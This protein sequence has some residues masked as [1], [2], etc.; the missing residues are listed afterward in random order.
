[1]NNIHNILLV[2][3]IVLSVLLTIAILLQPQGAS[4]GVMWGATSQSYH[5]RRGFEKILH[6]F[7]YVGVVLFVVVGLVILKTA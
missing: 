6:Y 4:S 5:T 1:M 7:T 3:Q 2:V